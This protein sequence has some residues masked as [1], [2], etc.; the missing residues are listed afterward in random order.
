MMNATTDFLGS[1]SEWRKVTLRLDDVH[2]LWGGQRV[3]VTGA[4]QISV[5]RVGPAFQTGQWKNTL[6]EI[7]TQALLHHFI[8]CD[9]VRLTLP[10]HTPVPDEAHPQITLTNAKGE[11]HSVLQWAGQPDRRFQTL[12]T[13]LRT[14][15]E[16]AVNAAQ[17]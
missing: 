13:A 16:Q 15:A 4:G 8:K 1:E 17:C 9:F 7:E 6:S 14:V 5:E 2:G 12:Y 3:A 10:A 11:N